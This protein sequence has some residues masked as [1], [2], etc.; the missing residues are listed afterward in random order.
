MS[1]D[2]PHTPERAAVRTRGGYQLAQ[3]TP[4]DHA[5]PALPHHADAKPLLHEEA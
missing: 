4:A 2:D 1:T 3:V 5:T